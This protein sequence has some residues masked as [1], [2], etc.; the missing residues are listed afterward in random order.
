MGDFV[1]NAHDFSAT[2]RSNT[3][4]F[5]SNIDISKTEVISWQETFKFDLWP[6]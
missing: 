1:S 2:T 6:E 4:E 3:M 5:I